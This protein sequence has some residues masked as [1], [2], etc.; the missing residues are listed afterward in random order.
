V[1]DTQRELE[2]RNRQ[3]EAIFRITSALYAKQN[4]DDML[5]ETL[6]VALEVV[7]ADA[8]TLYLYNP[9]H[10]T[11]VFR[12][13][14]GEKAD[15]LTGMEIP[16]DR[17]VAG[18]VFQ[19]GQPKI[20]EDASRE[21]R[22][23]RDVDAKTGY[24][25]RNMVTVPLRD[26]EGKPLGVLQAVNKR[27]GPFDRHD[28]EVLTVVATLAATAI[29]TV[30]M[31][32]ERRLAIIAR[33][34]GNISHDIKNM[35]T[36][37]LTTAQ[38]LHAFYQSFRAQLTHLQETLPPPA[39]EALLNALNP[40]DSFF[41][42]AVAM[43]EEGSAQIQERVREIADAVKGVVAEPQFIPTDVNEVAEKVLRALQPVAQKQGVKLQLERVTTVPLVLVDPKRLYNA[44]Y[45]LVNNAIPETP[46]GGSVTIRT[47]V[48]YDGEFPDGNYLGI[49]VADTG[50]GM[51]PE[52]K[53]RLFT[54]RA[55]S[56]KPGGTGLGTRI[57]K[58]IVDAH[59]G[60][61]WVDSELGKGTTV[62][63]RLPL[64]LAKPGPDEGGAAR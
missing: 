56:T 25:T 55:I 9:E 3:L 53:E 31:Q 28:L 16:A 21:A 37:I 27:D 57:V 64:R 45:N 36:P 30:R 5:Q 50:Q 13:V 58:N 26:I 19:S 54:D 42:E 6:R 38:T 40:F 60:K 48:R 23:L 63:I 15:E 22:H 49:E 14:V 47:Y 35:L 46:A 52:V 29:E 1:I 34:L 17:G 61:I 62:F 24:H 51:P 20:T 32:E 18:E 59:N 41:D 12:Y 10:N 43:I 8:G 33:L 7:S 4:L 39:R 44:L 2:K 11:L